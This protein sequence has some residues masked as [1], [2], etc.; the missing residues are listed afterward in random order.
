MVPPQSSFCSDADA[1]TIQAR[2]ETL[3]KS[4]LEKK[5]IQDDD[6]DGERSNP[7]PPLAFFT[8]EPSER[9]ERV[10]LKVRRSGSRGSTPRGT[11]AR[12][13]IRRKVVEIMCEQSGKF[14]NWFL[15]RRLLA[16]YLR[17]GMQHAGERLHP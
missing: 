7:G 14:K 8:Q 4:L 11:L 16:S 12:R 10:I 6:C 15:C 9:H 3:S 13:V 1:A 5:D 17:L 2:I